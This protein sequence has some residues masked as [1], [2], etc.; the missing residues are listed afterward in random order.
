MPTEPPD[1]EKIAVLTPMTLPST[2]ESRAAGIAFVH[3]RID[4]DEIVIGTGADIAAASRDDAGGDGAAEAERIAHRK[5]PIADARR[6]I[7]ELHIGEVFAV[8]LDQG[9]VG[10]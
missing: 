2:F 8:D 9:E 7:G 6:S 10:A 4:L 5:H 1:G 3:R